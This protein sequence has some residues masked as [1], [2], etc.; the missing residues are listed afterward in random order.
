MK[1]ASYGIV[2]T[3]LLAGSLAATALAADADDHVRN[4]VDN[5]LVNAVVHFVF[6]ECKKTES[7]TQTIPG[8]YIGW[9]RDAFP[10]KSVTD[11][12]DGL[13]MRREGNNCRSLPA[14]MPQQE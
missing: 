10:N 11:R 9:L 5:G 6:S 8:V 7:L 4:G 2:S 3:L 1:F 14:P 12:P 13:L